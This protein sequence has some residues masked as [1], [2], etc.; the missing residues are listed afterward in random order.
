MGHRK[1]SDYT[2]PLW[3]LPEVSASGSALPHIYN[4]LSPP[5]YLGTV[6]SFPFYFIIFTQGRGWIR[7]KLEGEMGGCEYDQNT[8]HEILKD[9]IKYHIKK[10]KIPLKKTT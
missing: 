6:M 10:I 2:C 9:L 8:M 7:E 5:L 4:K 3:A 1:T